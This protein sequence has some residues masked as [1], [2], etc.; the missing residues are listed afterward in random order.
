MVSGYISRAC[1]KLR[2]QGSV[3]QSI[4]VFIHTSPFSKGEGY[5]NSKNISLGQY[6]ADTATFITMGIYA[7]E[8]IFKD[9]Y[10]YQKAGIMLFDI[11]PDTH[12]QLCLFHGEKYNI[13]ARKRMKLLDHINARYGSQTLRLASENSNAGICTRII[14]HKVIQRSGMSYCL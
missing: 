3:A 5:S 1:E 8:R 12:Q 14:Y 7:L 13:E 6:T 10:E 2:K 11:L 9:G 4:T